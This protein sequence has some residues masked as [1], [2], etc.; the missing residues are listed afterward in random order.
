MTEQKINH[1]YSIILI[2]VSS[3]FQ[4]SIVVG[5]LY[6]A[7]KTTGIINTDIIDKFISEEKLK[8]GTESEKKSLKLAYISREIG[9]Q[10]KELLKHQNDMMRYG[11]IVLV[12]SIFLQIIAFV[13]IVKTKKR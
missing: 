4:L 12:L 7:N 13:C 11:A 6:M 3:V 5:H 10:A 1:T 9:L 8:D 2:V